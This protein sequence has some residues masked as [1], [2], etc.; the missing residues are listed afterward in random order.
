MVP[1]PLAEMYCSGGDGS[2]AGSGVRRR[3]VGA[4]RRTK[5]FNHA[6]HILVGHRGLPS[7]CLLKLLQLPGATTTFCSRPHLYKKKTA[8]A[9]L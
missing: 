4:A 6:N 7:L 8:A 1:L 2:L 3:G 5:P 9:A